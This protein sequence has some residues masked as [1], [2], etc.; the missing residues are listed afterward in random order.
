MF[1]PLGL[2]IACVPG[3]ASAHTLGVASAS[4]DAII[5]GWTL[6]FE[7]AVLVTWMAVIGVL[8]AHFSRQRSIFDWVG[9]LF[10]GLGIGVFGGQYLVLSEPLALALL[11][12]LALWITI[13]YGLSPVAFCII[14]VAVGFIAGGLTRQSHPELLA[15][16][17]IQIAAIAALIM[18][19]MMVAS[20]LRLPGDR[21]PR[22]GE[23]LIRV[24]GSW[25]VALAAMQSAFLIQ[26]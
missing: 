9:F 7:S 2:L 16:W 25:M 8:L 15:V 23:V 24:I 17:S 19:P 1:N 4:W 5:I 21:F 20:T 13:F 3:I 18:V 11:A 10:V 6:P 14:L 26:A 12:I 22:F